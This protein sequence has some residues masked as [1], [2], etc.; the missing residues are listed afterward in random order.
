MYTSAV[1]SS[2]ALTI[3][4]P[5][6]PNEALSTG[7]K[8]PLCSRTTTPV[9][10]S[11]VRSVLSALL[12]TTRYDLGGGCARRVVIASYSRDHKTHH[13]SNEEINKYLMLERRPQLVRAEIPNA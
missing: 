11:H 3:T 4:D 7:A 1:P 8:W 13:S 10:A 5:P 6:R 12:E 2:L 9:R